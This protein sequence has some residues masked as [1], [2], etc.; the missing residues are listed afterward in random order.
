[1]KTQIKK[2]GDSSVIVLS[3]DFMKYH[4]VQIGDWMDLSDIIILSDKL[5]QIKDEQN[6]YIN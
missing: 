3:S 1:M 4:G 6:G 5:K 2:W